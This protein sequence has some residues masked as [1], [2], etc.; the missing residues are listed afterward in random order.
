M[1]KYDAL[2][3]LKSLYAKHKSG[4]DELGI[5]DDVLDLIEDAR[6]VQREDFPV[7]VS[8]KN[9]KPKEIDFLTEDER[10]FIEHG[11]WRTK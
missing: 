6:L 5:G 8:F 2:E 9:V 11:K 10:Y 7:F 3:A 4:L 1:D